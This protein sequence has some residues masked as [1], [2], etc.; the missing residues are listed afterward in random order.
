MLPSQPLSF[1]SRSCRFVVCSLWFQ[2]V[3]VVG[4]CFFI[5]VVAVVAAADAV[6]VCASG[7]ARAE[8]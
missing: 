4:P 3:S 2:I 1:Q 6:A 8:G 7:G 5:V